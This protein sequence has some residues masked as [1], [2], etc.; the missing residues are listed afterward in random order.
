MSKWTDPDKKQKAF[1]LNRQ[2]MN[3]ID[4]YARETDQSFDD[5]IKEE[6]EMFE[7]LLIKKCSVI[8]EIRIKAYE[9]SRK[10]REEQKLAEQSPLIVPGHEVNPLENDPITV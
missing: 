7:Q 8:E 4:S 9:A 3:T 1:V 10:A 6:F 5:V 2:V